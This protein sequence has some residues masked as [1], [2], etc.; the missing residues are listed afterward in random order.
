MVSVHGFVFEDEVFFCSSAPADAVSSGWLVELWS[1]VVGDFEEDDEEKQ[2]LP[3][4][5]R[6]IEAGDLDY[7]KQAVRDGRYKM[8]WIDW[9]L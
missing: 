2:N 9:S 1:G 7:M 4:S 6:R 3:N 5:D 8:K